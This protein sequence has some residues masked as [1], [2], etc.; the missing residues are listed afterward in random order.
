[1]NTESTANRKHCPWWICSN[2]VCWLG[3]VSECVYIF[4][5]NSSRGSVSE[6]DEIVKEK[7]KWSI[8]L[9][10]EEKADKDVLTIEMKAKIHCFEIDRKNMWKRKTF[11]PPAWIVFHR[12]QV[13]SCFISLFNN[14]NIQ[15]YSPTLSSLHRT[16]C[17]RGY[18]LLLC[19][20]PSL[21]GILFFCNQCDQCGFVCDC[22]SKLFQ[23]LLLV[24]VAAAL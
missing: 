20:P 3:R 16:Q 10:I 5:D 2:N 24:T 23:L 12:L 9:T 13:F 8:S 11:R 21:V 6:G 1:M 14:S 18:L 4:Q 15:Q 19:K 7:L 22:V 17:E